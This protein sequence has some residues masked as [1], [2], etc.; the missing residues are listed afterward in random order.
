MIFIEKTGFPFTFAGGN[1]SISSS[2]LDWKHALVVEENVY[3]FR[4]LQCRETISL[5]SESKCCYCIWNPSFESV[6]VTDKWIIDAIEQE[7]L[8]YYVH[9]VRY[10]AKLDVF[11]KVDWVMIDLSEKPL[12]NA[13]ASLKKLVGRFGGDLSYLI[14][15]E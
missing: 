1:K 13:V 8:S 11:S 14:P 5:D 7:N 10:Q 3:T 4:I 9:R 12:T 2:V 15:P 6:S